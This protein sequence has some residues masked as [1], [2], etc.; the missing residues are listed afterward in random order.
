MA[1]APIGVPPAFR[2][3]ARVAFARTA[4]QRV[5]RVVFASPARTKS[6]DA[7]IFATAR[8]AFL[9]ARSSPRRSISIARAPVRLRSDVRGSRA[10]RA[11]GTDSKRSNTQIQSGADARETIERARFIR[12]RRSE[13]ARTTVRRRLFSALPARRRPQTPSL[14]FALPIAV[15]GAKTRP[16][17]QIAFAR[18]LRTQRGHAPRLEHLERPQ[19]ETVLVAAHVMPVEL[20][21]RLLFGAAHA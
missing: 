10:G 12:D 18:L 21:R 7:R 20:V 1:A 16:L 11:L 5:A 17:K 8:A 6:G 4:V 19:A 9:S 2:G 3:F 14:R 15:A 13:T